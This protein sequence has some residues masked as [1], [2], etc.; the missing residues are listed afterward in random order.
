MVSCFAH[1]SK[2]APVIS[3][4]EKEKVL[5]DPRATAAAAAAAAAAAK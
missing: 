5:A 2:S 4:W 3:K 1:L